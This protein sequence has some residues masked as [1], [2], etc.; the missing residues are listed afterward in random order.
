MNVQAEVSFYPLRT[1]HMGGAIDC[2]V[3]ALQQE[4]VEVS[5]GSMSTRLE[6]EADKVFDAVRQAFTQTAGKCPSV[7]VL[8]LSNSCPAKENKSN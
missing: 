8:K 1:E 4:H 2:F 3:E 6:G 7:L 5:V